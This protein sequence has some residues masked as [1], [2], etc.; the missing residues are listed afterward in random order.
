MT[1]QQLSYASLLEDTRHNK[2]SERVIDSQI[3]ANKASATYSK[4]A[5]RKATM[6]GANSA[7]SGVGKIIHF[8]TGL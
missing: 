5:A 2:E 3:L 1:S 8:F 6:D 7:I 4:A